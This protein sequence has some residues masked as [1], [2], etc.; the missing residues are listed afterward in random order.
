MGLRMMH[1]IKQGTHPLAK[2]L[3]FALATAIKSNRSLAG[4][5]CKAFFQLRRLH[6][7]NL[8]CSIQQA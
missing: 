6:M 1:G 8:A 7:G 3:S 2:T 4:G 5:L